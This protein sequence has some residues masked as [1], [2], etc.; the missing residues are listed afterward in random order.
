VCDRQSV[1]RHRRSRQFKHAR[2][3]Q[4][5]TTLTSLVHQMSHSAHHSSENG[6][7]TPP[8]A[9]S[10]ANI[11]QTFWGSF[12]LPSFGNLRP[13]S[14]FSLN[15][16]SIQGPHSDRST[17]QPP[18]PPPCFWASDQMCTNK[19]QQISLLSHQHWWHCHLCATCCQRVYEGIS[20]VGVLLILQSASA[21]R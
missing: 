9:C 3:D 11:S 6:A 5:T 13:S 17:F 7:I 12:P 10:L 19:S 16:A 2:C 14:P 15:Y 18:S 4:I 21:G 20:R 1:P 8:P